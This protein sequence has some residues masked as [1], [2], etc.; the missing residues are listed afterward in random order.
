VG[1]SAPE[2]KK[3]AYLTVSLLAIIAVG[4]LFGISSADFPQ[5]IISLAPNVTE[6]LFA[7]GAADR[8]VG[9]SN[10]CDFPEE[11][12]QKPKVGGLSNPSLEAVVSL[13]P[14]LV[15]LTKDGNPKA[16]E[17]RLRAMRIR[18]LVLTARKISD[19]PDAIRQVGTAVGA[20]EKAERLAVDIEKRTRAFEERGKSYRVLHAASK[21]P[22]ALFIIW[23]E[24]LIVAGPATTAD[25]ALT[26]LGAE[27][28]AAKTSSAYP[29]YSIEEILRQAPDV[30]FI[31]K[32]TGMDKVADGLL[33]RLSSVPAVRNKKVFY[34]SDYLY[35]LGPRTIQGVEELE[36]L[37]TLS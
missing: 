15:F 18:T 22:K 16:F 19:L 35:R 14:D 27:N 6:I 32:G 8:I 30:I 23:P 9:V 29:K 31:G 37:L 25:E 26:L 4:S 33:K 36:R 10:F 21:K 7:L 12:K 5:R 28:I 13:K 1:I 34:V 20:R 11:A 17:E 3:S 24:P 2:K